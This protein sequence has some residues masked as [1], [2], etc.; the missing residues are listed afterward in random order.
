MTGKK[1]TRRKSPKTRTASLA[2]VKGMDEH[3]IMSF[4]ALSDPTPDKMAQAISAVEKLSTAKVVRAFPGMLRIHVSQG[5]K[6]KVRQ[7]LQALEE[8]DVSEEAMA[9]MPTG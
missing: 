4:K 2:R 8:W 1:I 3:L 6:E 5:E 7:V 9:S